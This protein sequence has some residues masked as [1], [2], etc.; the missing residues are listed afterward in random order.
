MCDAR[1]SGEKLEKEP[2]SRRWYG[3][4]L[5]LWSVS[6]DTRVDACALYNNNRNIVMV[7]IITFMIIS[8]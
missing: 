4:S 7:S 1:I 6:L 3:L 8:Y 2:S 5:P